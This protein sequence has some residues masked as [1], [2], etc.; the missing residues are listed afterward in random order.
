MVRLRFGWTFFPL[1]ILATL[2]RSIKEE[3]LQLPIQ[4]CFTS[5]PAISLTGQTWSGLDG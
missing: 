4:T 1:R 3:L 2:I 5:F